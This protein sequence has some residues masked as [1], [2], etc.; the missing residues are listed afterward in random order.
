MTTSQ[1]GLEAFTLYLDPNDPEDAMIIRYLKPKV[2]RKKAASELRTAMI[3]YLE[4]LKQGTTSRTIHATLSE[5][6]PVQLEAP[7]NN[8][9]QAIQKARD[10][11][12]RRSG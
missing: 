5:P 2:R 6:I 9:N 10:S 8:G 7:P 3:L 11:F 12:M 1:S 4:Y